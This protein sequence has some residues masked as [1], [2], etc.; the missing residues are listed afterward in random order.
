[1]VMEHD[2][3]GASAY[4]K[5]IQEK[6]ISFHTNIYRYKQND[7]ASGSKCI[8]SELVKLGT[9]MAFLQAFYKFQLYQNKRFLKNKVVRL[10][11]YWGYVADSI[12]IP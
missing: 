7:T 8:W 6:K 9:L 1:M 3:S 5:V 4:S 12:Q 11:V 10:S 2:V